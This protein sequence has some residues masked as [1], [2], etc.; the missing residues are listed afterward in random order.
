MCRIPFKD[1]TILN[2]KKISIFM[3]F[4]LISIF[5]C[6]APLSTI[7]L[8]YTFSGLEST[9]SPHCICIMQKSLI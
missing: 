3:T 4:P 2:N 9:P 8:S 6:L 5:I 7:E 1:L